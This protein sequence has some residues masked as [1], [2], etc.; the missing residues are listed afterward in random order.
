MGEN[1]YYN[2]YIATTIGAA[3]VALSYLLLQ[4]EEKNLKKYLQLGLDFSSSKGDFLTV[5]FYIFTGII[6]GIVVFSFIYQLYTGKST[7]KFDLF[8]I[9]FIGIAEWIS[10]LYIKRS[11]KFI[12]KINKIIKENDSNKN[13]M[14]LDISLILIIILPFIYFTVIIYREILVNKN[15]EST[16]VLFII[17]CFAYIFILKWFGY[18]KT[19]RAV[20]DIKEFTI[21]FNDLS[22]KRYKILYNDGN[23]ILVIDDKKEFRYIN[24]D[25]MKS[26]SSS[27]AIPENLVEVK[28]NSDLKLKFEMTFPNKKHRR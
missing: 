3:I 26:I 1:I 27:E 4:T 25:I 11:S 9:V 5:I 28:D 16:L 21:Y 10:I 24:K 17:E 2:V 14:K 22:I 6:V 19:L 8:D 20:C 12:E 15:G 7:L 13:R 18:L 23:F